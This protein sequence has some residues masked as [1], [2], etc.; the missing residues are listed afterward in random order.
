[1]INKLEDTQVGSVLSHFLDSGAY[2]LRKEKVTDYLE[3][4]DRYADFVK[5][6]SSAIDLYANVDVIGDPETT[7]QNQKY[8]ERQGIS[9]VPVVHYGEEIKWIE[10]YLSEGYE[11]IAL[12]G[13]A[14]N[15]RGIDGW[16]GACFNVLCDAK[17]NLRAKVHGFG[18][19]GVGPILRYPWHSVDTVRWAHLGSRGYLA[20]PRLRK[21]AFKYDEEPYIIRIGGSPQTYKAHL[22]NLRMAEKG[23]VKRWLDYIGIDY[24][25]ITESPYSWYLSYL[26]FYEELS[27]YSASVPCMIGR[28]KGLLGG[29]SSVRAVTDRPQTL[30]YYSG[31]GIS[32]AWPEVSLEGRGRIMLTFYD[33]PTKRFEAVL[34][35][36]QGIN[37]VK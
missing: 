32:Q 31:N 1:M 25:T 17:G 4:M 28:Q 6:N 23:V 20:V 10:K 27:K 14:S 34:Q 33:Q 5:T 26:R 3:Y 2:S 22:L 7:Y 19:G 29:F 13:L 11:L 18:V 9:P 12:G 16:L 36:R 37:H 21:G 8:L 24:D 15:H 30:I 35:S